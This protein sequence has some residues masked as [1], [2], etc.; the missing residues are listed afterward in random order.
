MDIGE[1]QVLDNTR[2]VEICSVVGS[3]GWRPY[4]GFD[5]IDDFCLIVGDDD[6]NWLWYGDRL[7]WRGNCNVWLEGLKLLDL[8]GNVLK[9]PIKTRRHP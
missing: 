4:L 2:M 9:L 7:L 6:L 8:Y 5:F 3:V 1:R